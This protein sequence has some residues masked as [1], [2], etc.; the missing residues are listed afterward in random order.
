[1]YEGFHPRFLEN[2]FSIIQVS[3][4]TQDST[5]YLFVMTAAKFGVRQLF[6][7]LRRYHQLRF[8]CGRRR[9]SE[10][11]QSMVSCDL[12]LQT[13]ARPRLMS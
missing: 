12:S 7:V 8:A 10:L 2:I 5:K 13:T 9:G 1:M 4:N 3:G 6:A 11:T